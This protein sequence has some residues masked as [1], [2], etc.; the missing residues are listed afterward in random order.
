MKKNCLILSIVG[1]LLI[2]LSEIQAQITQ[3][4]PNQVELMKQLVGNW[5]AEWT[6]TILNWECKAFGTG[7][8]CYYNYTLT[9]NNKKVLEGRQLFGYDSKLD[10]YVAATLETGRD[11]WILAF[12]FT[13]DNNYKIISLTDISDPDKAFFKVE[14]EFKSPDAFT[15]TWILNGK[16]FDRY[17]YIRVK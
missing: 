16:V 3:A 4:K 7:L 17:N 9:K 6:D 10:K 15:E 14:G 11:I 8:D 13:S 12:W 1:F 5:K 2:G